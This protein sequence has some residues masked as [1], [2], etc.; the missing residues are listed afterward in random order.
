VD[1]RAS[2]KHEAAFSYL[3]PNGMDHTVIVMR[4]TVKAAR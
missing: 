2:L 4:T 1:S 3:R